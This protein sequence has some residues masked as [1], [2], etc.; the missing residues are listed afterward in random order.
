M[1]RSMHV[2]SQVHTVIIL[3]LVLWALARE[4]Q[5]IREDKAFGWDDNVGFVHAVA[6]G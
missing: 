4:G 6:C 1:R 2:V 3:P 5:A